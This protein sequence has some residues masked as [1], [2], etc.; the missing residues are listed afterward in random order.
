VDEIEKKVL[1]YI[2]VNRLVKPGE[3]IV[4]GVSG[5]VD[6]VALVYVLKQISEELKINLVVAH[7]NH[8]LRGD[9]SDG[10]EQFVC[11]LARKMNLPFKCERGDVKCLVEKERMSIEMAARRLRHLFLARTAKEYGAKKIA[12]AHHS[13]DQIE[14]F[15][16]RLLRGS[17]SAGLSCMKPI[18]PSPVDTDVCLIRPFL[19]LWRREIERYARDKYLNYREDSTNA[20]TEYLRNRIRNELIPLLKM[21]Y[22]PGIEKIILR[23]IEILEAESDYILNQA[24]EWLNTRSISFSDL[25]EAIQR[26][27]IQIQLINNGIEADFDLVEKLRLKP[28]KPVT[29]N[30]EFEALLDNDGIVRIIPLENKDYYRSLHSENRKQFA[31]NSGE[32]IINFEEM[33]IKWSV[34]PLQSGKS[35]LLEAKPK[36]VEYFDFDKIGKNITLRHWNE[37]DRFRPIG[38][39]DY[40]KLQDL[41][42]NNKIPKEKRH[43]LLV[44]AAA[45]G[46]IF[47]IEG[48]RISDKYKIT[49]QT[50]TILKWEWKPARMSATTSLQ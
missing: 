45:D 27:C 15:F 8:S 21:E 39:A 26:K 32:G 16:L 48:F 50:K 12:V 5:G 17:S 24:Q 28:N 38:F 19:N 44:A 42:V 14:L 4:V 40:V 25:H 34:E 7:F 33:E 2:R 6:S 23:Q 30:S 41:F 18:S 22:Q 13:D 49:D 29:V 11:E 9:E 10:D 43:S 36:N 3:T 46:E 1:D 35:Q 47:W 20:A 37:G 31:L